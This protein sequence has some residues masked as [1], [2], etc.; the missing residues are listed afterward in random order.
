VEDGSAYIRASGL[1]PQLRL[2]LPQFSSRR[3]RRRFRNSDVKFQLRARPKRRDVSSRHS[4]RIHLYLRFGEASSEC[5]RDCTNSSFTSHRP[6]LQ[7]RLS[8]GQ[9][10][11]SAQYPVFSLVVAEKTGSHRTK[12]RVALPFQLARYRRASLLH[13]SLL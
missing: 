6:W 13:Y 7:R 10:N 3:L 12:Q 4:S 2:R 9:L 8:F 1:R 5:E 11:H